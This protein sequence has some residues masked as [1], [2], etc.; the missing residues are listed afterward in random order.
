[1]KQLP[2]ERTKKDFTNT[3][4]FELCIKLGRIWISGNL[5][6]QQGR[7]RKHHKHKY[8]QV[9]RKAREAYCKED[10]IDVEIQKVNNE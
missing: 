5:G 3:V 9:S 10:S 4:V 7:W 2:T 8:M 6:Q 1:M